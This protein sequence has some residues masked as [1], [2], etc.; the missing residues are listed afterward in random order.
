[1][2]RVKIVCTIGP[3]CDDPNILEQLIDSGMNVARLNMSHGSHQYHAQNIARIRELSQKR[4]KPVAILGDLQGPK[5]RVGKMQEGGV[6]LKAGEELILSA[7]ESLGKPGRVPLQNKEIPG[8]VRPGERILLDDGLLE[9]EVTGTTE[10]EIITRVIV[11]GTL[12]D[13]KG[14]NLPHS[15]L[16]I[17]SLTPKDIADVEFLLQQQVDWIALSFVRQAQDVEE[18]RRMIRGKAG[19]GRTTPIISKIEKPDAVQNIRE[20][21]D[22]S[23]GIMVARGD[24]GIETSPEAVPMVQKMIINY[25]NETDVPVITATQMLDSMIRN[26]RPT[27]AEASDV[28][29][30]VLDGSDAIMLSG[31]TASG[32]YPVRAVQTMVK[33]AEEAE[34]VRALT[35]QAKPQAPTTRAATIAGAVSRATV[36]TAQEVNA[37]A[38]I[39][40]TV[41]G[42][43]AKKLARY[44]PNVPIIAVTPSPVVHRQ[45]ALY[46]GVYT[47]L[48]RRMNTTDE[49][50][51]DAVRLAHRA[52]Y[53]DQGDI[54]LVT[55]GV[56]GGIPGA[57][58]LMTVRKIARVLVTG[59]GVGNRRASGRV[60]RMKPG[61]TY[62]SLNVTTQD[63]LV[64]ERID[65]SWSE[66][67]YQV[68]GLITAEPGR[69]SYAALAAVELGIPA[70]VGARGHWDDLK[71]HQLIV[72]DAVTGSAYDGNY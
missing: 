7:E 52:G 32:S 36:S 26:P 59:D 21:I 66:L 42:S 54:V 18:L 3:A 69:E 55:G 11:G 53:V 43:T 10:T 29:N 28:A 25:C 71:D 35:P 34:R 45:L 17:P 23:D 58:N 41:S 70:L 6:P 12:F 31:E 38:I 49:V 27:R 67:V 15:K 37:A 40:P 50:V 56:V 48:G 51:E 62:D 33:I 22:A 44:R 14:M 24:L 2:L 57:T 13:N 19:F 46:W 65:P 61:Q 64:A 39:A 20:I 47:I 1:M 72:L 9:L 16:D 60:I 63:I 30:A 8:M 5:L 4:N 68:G